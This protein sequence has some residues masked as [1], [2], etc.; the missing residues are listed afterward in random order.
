MAQNPTAKPAANARGDGLRIVV[1]TARFNGAVTEKMRALCDEELRALGV[2][3]IGHFAVPGALELPFALSRLATREEADALVALGCVI[4]GETRH[5][6]IVADRSAQGILFAQFAAK[7]P[8][9]N[10]V[11]TVEDV[12]QAED[13]VDKGRECARAAVEMARL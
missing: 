9:I 13:R 12:A 5:F 1:V 11:L 2:S 8:M 10:G 6:E 3:Q 4:R 7:K